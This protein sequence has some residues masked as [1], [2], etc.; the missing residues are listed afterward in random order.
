VAG[1]WEANGANTY[2]RRRGG[3]IPETA[4]REVE[5]EGGSEAR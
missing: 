2:A 3:I 5:E 1:E 4:V